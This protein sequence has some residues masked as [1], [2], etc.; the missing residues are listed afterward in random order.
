[1]AR[2]SAAFALKSFGRITRVAKA[3][4]RLGQR[5]LRRGLLLVQPRDR[6]ARFRL[7]RIEPGDLFLDAI[8]F[9]ADEV[10][11]LLE[12]RFVIVGALGLALHADDGFFLPVNF[13]GQPGDRRRRVRH[14]LFEAGGLGRSGDPAMPWPR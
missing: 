3:P 12:A 5:D 11:A 9:R 2:A 6:F 8:D 1:M 13:V 10:D 14:R 4:L 7:P